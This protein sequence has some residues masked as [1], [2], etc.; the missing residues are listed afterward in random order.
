M[1]R[2]GKREL[3]SQVWQRDGTNVMPVQNYSVRGAIPVA[4]KTARLKGLSVKI[5]RLPFCLYS[6]KVA[7]TTKSEQMRKK[8]VTVK[9]KMG[10]RVS[11]YLT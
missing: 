4:M 3:Q 7:C 5:G 1:S 8:K 9:K 2:K 6:S 10:L 11:A